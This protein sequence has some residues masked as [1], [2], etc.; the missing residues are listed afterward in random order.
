MFWIQFPMPAWGGSQRPLTPDSQTPKP[1]SSVEGSTHVHTPTHKDT[2]KLTNEIFKKL[3]LVREHWRVA[4]FLCG[5]ISPR[6]LTPSCAGGGAAFLR[7]TSCLTGISAERGLAARGGPPAV[8]TTGKLV[9]V[10]ES[11]E[12]L[13]CDRG[14]YRTKRK[15]NKHSCWKKRIYILISSQSFDTRINLLTMR[16]GF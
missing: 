1:S 12:F 16:H 5:L 9:G 8:R 2:H 13:A 4:G 10:S 14:T 7:I 15:V 11:L 6:P 3:R